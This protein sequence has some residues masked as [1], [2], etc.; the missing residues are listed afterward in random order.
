LLTTLAADSFAAACRCV[1]SYTLRWP[2]AVSRE[3]SLTPS[4]QV[5]ARLTDS[6]LV[7][8]E[9]PGRESQPGKPSD[10][11]LGRERAQR[12]RLQRAVKAEGAS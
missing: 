5:R 12:S 2:V 8:R 11:P 3:G 4:V 7:A 6:G 1:H 9:A 10:N